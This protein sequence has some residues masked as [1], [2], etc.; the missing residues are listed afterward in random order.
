[1]TNHSDSTRDREVLDEALSQW[2]GAQA[3]AD[4]LTEDAATYRQLFCQALGYSHS[5]QAENAQLRRRVRAL[6]ETNRHLRQAIDALQSRA[7]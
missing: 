3:L 6:Q 1:M 2:L 7:A 4:S 5:L